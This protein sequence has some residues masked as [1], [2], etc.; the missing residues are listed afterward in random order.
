METQSPGRVHPCVKLG[1][2]KTDI[3]AAGQRMVKLSSAMHMSGDLPKYPVGQPATNTRDMDPSPV[4]GLER[5]EK[6]HS[7]L[8]DKVPRRDRAIPEDQPAGGQNLQAV[9]FRQSLSTIKTLK[10]RGPAVPLVFAKTA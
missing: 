3:L 7:F 5:C 6:A 2:L 8:S 4:N 9:L 1:D 10:D